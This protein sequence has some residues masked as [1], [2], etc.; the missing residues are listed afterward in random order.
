[1]QHFKIQGHFKA[2]LEFEVDTGAL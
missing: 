1:L 2:R